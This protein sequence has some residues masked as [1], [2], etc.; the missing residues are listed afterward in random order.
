MTP[1]TK[2]TTSGNKGRPH[3][4]IHRAR[5]SE[6]LKKSPAAAKQRAVLHAAR[7]GTH[8]SAETRAKLSLAMTGK[9]FP[10]KRVSL[11]TRA[12]ISAAKMG[13]TRLGCPHTPETKAK[14][15]A[16]NLGRRHG[17]EARA[18]MGAARKGKPRSPETRA[19]ISA[20]NAGQRPSPEHLA[21]FLIA[22]RMWKQ[23]NKDNPKR[24]EQLR[25]MA[26]ACRLAKPSS[27]ER[28]IRS[29]L[30]RLEIIYLPEHRIGPYIV[31]IFI[32]DKRLVVECDGEYWHSMPGAKERDAKRDSYMVSR[33]F[34]VLRLPEKEIRNRQS[35]GPLLLAVGIKPN[36]APIEA[37]RT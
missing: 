12:K 8:I 6:A 36:E 13:K 1:E 27:I 17:P 34:T 3:S 5:I 29:L 23:K 9:R 37:R 20:A 25:N 11:E 7:K 4:L 30:E 33:G 24:L 35:E 14:I 26:A 18:N 19:R 15:S 31:D 2:E 22:S 10:G 16:A 32:P 28:I 21:K